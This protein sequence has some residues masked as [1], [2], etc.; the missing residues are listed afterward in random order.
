MMSFNTNKYLYT[1]ASTGLDTNKV[2]TFITRNEAMD[3]MYKL[4]RRYDLVIEEIWND[5]HDRTY[6]CNDGVSFYIQRCN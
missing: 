1:L 4:C 6:N 2:L 5:N 3:Y